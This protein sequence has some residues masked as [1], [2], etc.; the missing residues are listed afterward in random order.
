M[1]DLRLQYQFQ[2]ECFVL[3]VISIK[4]KILRFEQI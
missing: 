3:N 2:G 4:Y 1:L